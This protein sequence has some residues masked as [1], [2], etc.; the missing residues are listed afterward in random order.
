VAE[1]AA[2]IRTSG[3]LEGSIIAAVI[4]CQ[5]AKNRTTAPAAGGPSASTQ[6]W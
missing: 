3:R 6:S 2:N 1:A 5:P 4:T